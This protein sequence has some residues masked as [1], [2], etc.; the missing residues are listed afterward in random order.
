MIEIHLCH[1]MEFRAEFP[2]FEWTNLSPKLAILK[3]NEDGEYG[4]NYLV[5]R[6][7]LYIQKQGD[8][9]QLC[10]FWVLGKT[11]SLCM[12]FSDSSFHSSDD[13]LVGGLWLKPKYY[14][15]ELNA[16]QNRVY[17]GKLQVFCDLFTISKQAVFTIFYKCFETNS[18]QMDFVN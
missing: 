13:V 14:C 10:F 3:L 12:L 17:Y 7:D 2:E 6:W 8:K 9:T 16:C 15:R 5:E 4:V 18:Y 1:T 11:P